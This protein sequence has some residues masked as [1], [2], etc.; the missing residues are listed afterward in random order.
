MSYYP[1]DHVSIS[2]DPWDQH[3]VVFGKSG[4]G[5]TFLLKNKLMRDIGRSHVA[6]CWVWDSQGQY[7][8]LAKYGFTVTRSLSDLP[9]GKV[10]VQPQ[11][12]SDEDFNDVCERAFNIRNIVIVVEE[13][14]FYVGKYTI[15]SKAFNEIVKGGRP[16]GVTYIA[17]TIRPQDVHNTVITQA[18][19]RFCFA[20]EV[21]TDYD[22]L[23]RWFGPKTELLKPPLIRDRRRLAHIPEV[24]RDPSLADLPLPDH[25]FVYRDPVGNVEVGRL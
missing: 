6:A 13:A 25:S 8:D 2:Y 5:K 7:A 12:I 24:R 4:T 16:R 23:Y 1:L 17:V 19:H 21:P 3:A 10:V 15:R 18:S 11:S 9:Y 20:L 14:H 22:Y